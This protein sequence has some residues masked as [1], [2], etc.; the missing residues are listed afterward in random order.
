MKLIIHDLSER[1]FTKLELSQDDDMRIISDDGTIKSCVG[2]FGCWIKTPG[3][4][5]LNDKYNNMGELL[6]R[7]D[8]LVVI[9]RLVY[10]SYSP[11][12]RNVLDR[13]IPYLL[14]YFTVINGEIHHQPRYENRLDLTVHFYGD[15]MEER[16]KETAKQLVI[17]NAVNL[18]AN[19]KDVNFHKLAQKRVEEYNCSGE[20]ENKPSSKMKIALLNGSPKQGASTSGWMIGKLEEIIG[21]ECDVSS[22]NLSRTEIEDGIYD[23]LCNMD[24]LVIS[25]PLY[26]D[27]IPSHLF[28]ILVELEKRM[29]KLRLVEPQ[30]ENI[31]IDELLEEDA[32]SSRPRKKD[33][34]VYAILHNGFYE[35]SQ[36]YIALD[37][38]KNWCNRSGVTYAQGIAQG[39]GEVVGFVETVP[40]GHGPLKNLGLALYE[41]AENIKA[42]S[43]GEDKLFNPNLPRLMWRLMASHSF[44]QPQA[45]KN[46]LKIRD[47]RNR[48]GYMK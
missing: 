48:H 11:F 45:R 24:A 36:N 33:T 34:L 15:D 6:A 32:E 39:S 4:C 35:G 23:D 47:I 12:I 29:N 31:H 7:C 43:L 37:I 26:V 3:R 27:A 25:C 9:S 2:C 16:E 5:V 44:W 14:P 41:L 20:C 42:S 40:L 21:D 13:S 17:A 38:I 22:F 18:Y 8:E 46:G 19:V 30:T 10:G 28:R 1:E